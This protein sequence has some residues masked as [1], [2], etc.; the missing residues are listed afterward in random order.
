MG[1]VSCYLTAVQRY[2][3]A[4]R[5]ASIGRTLAASRWDQC[6]D[7][8]QGPPMGE[9]EAPVG[10]ERQLGCRHERCEMTSVTPEV[11]PVSK[12]VM[13]TLGDFLKQRVEPWA[14]ARSA[15]PW[16]WAGIRPLLEAK[17]IAG[18]ALNE[19]TSEVAGGYAA[20][21][22]A[23][24]V[25][26]TVNRELRVLRRVLRLAVEWGLLSQA[27]KITMLRGETFRER[28]VGDE[29]FEKY[30]LCAS[31]LL[32]DVVIL[33]HDTGLRPDEAH[34]VDWSDI[35]L[36]NG[37]HGKLRVRYGKTTAARREL[38]L[39]PRLRAVLEARWQNAGRPSEGW[40]FPTQ[41]K[42]G[43]IDHSSLKKQ[44]SK[45]LRLSGV[46]SFLLYSLRHSFATHIAPRVDAWTLCKIMGWSSLSVAMR[47]IHPS[48]D[49]VLAAFA[50]PQLNGTGDKT[51][52]SHENGVA[53][54]RTPEL[55]SG[56]ISAS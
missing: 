36:V 7:S 51:G 19:I 14:R 32:A 11:S 18:L 20:H 49:R 37:R 53:D 34:R 25:I 10:I 1:F 33:L 45:A 56:R 27:P 6:Q 47:Y 38:P 17:S 39:T 31:P 35:A 50:G 42:S 54:A 46:R 41:S 55:V 44:H 30:L 4:K 26:G 40:V 24:V 43:H 13:P 52:D 8:P 28:V 48:E 2:P 12:K 22:Q 21:R 15:W 16:Y 9:T 29:E 23:S 3:L 5:S